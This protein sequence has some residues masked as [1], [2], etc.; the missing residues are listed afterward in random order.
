M[1]WTPL[2]DR[3]STLPLVLTGPVLRRVEPDA[4]TVWLVLREPHEVR[5][6]VLATEA[7]QGIVPQAVVLEGA[8][9]TTAL[10]PYLHLVAVTARPR[11]EQVLAPDQVYAYDLTFGD[12]DLITALMP[13][14][15]TNPLPPAP[16]SY[17]DHQLPTFS[18]PP[19]DLDDLCIVHGS[20]RKPHGEG[21]DALV[22]LD[23][24]IGHHATSGRSRPHQLF[25]TGDQI[26]GDDV[27]DPLLWML[28]DAGETLLGWQEVLPLLPS[29]RHPEE[30]LLASQI[31]PGE[32]CAI[33]ER[34]AGFTAM[35]HGNEE[36]A[37]SHLLSLAE[38]LAMYLFVW[39]PVLWPEE[40]PPFLDIRQA[41]SQRAQGWAKESRLLQDFGRDLGRVRRAL[42]NVPTYMICDDHDVTDDW[43]LNREW[44]DR[45][46]SKPLGRRV[47]TNAMLGYALCQ[48]WGNTPDQF[49]AGQPGDRLLDLVRQWSASCGT[50]P[51]LLQDISQILGL[52]PTVTADSVTERDRDFHAQTYIADEAVEILRR[53]PIA[54]HAVLNW[55]YT[56]R[57]PRHEVLVLDT[58]TWRGYPTDGDGFSPPRLLS[59]TAFGQQLQ[60]PLAQAPPAIALTL[61]V[62]PTNLISLELIDQIQIFALDQGRGFSTDAGDSWNLNAAAFSRL[63]AELF[64]QRDRVVILTGDIHYSSA[65][66]L[67]YWSYETRQSPRACVLAQLTAS[68]YKNAETK[69]RLVHTKL[70]ALV[71]EVPQQWA[72]WHRPPHLVEV[73]VSPE[74]V[75]YLKAD[76]PAEGP[77]LRQIHRFRGNETLAWAIAIQDPDSLPDWQYQFEWIPRPPA[78]DVPWMRWPLTQKPSRLRRWLTWPWRNR[79]FQEGREV[80]GLNN[81]SIVTVRWSAEGEKAVCQDVYWQTP[82]Q[83]DHLV[84]SRYVVPLTPAPP[85]P[86]LKLYDEPVTD[87]VPALP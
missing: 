77:V 39:S 56:V 35:A 14:Q 21:R 4:V 42:A 44:C 3:L 22:M 81:I 61:V 38:Y 17:F 49:E 40:L 34:Q 7:G 54:D 62:L 5:L 66:L 85:P 43:Y 12:R 74:G 84:Y 11:G 46:L 6:S 10:G 30:T 52:P 72:G 70:K 13:P 20:C 28:T 27:A 37:K 2:R 53:P 15:E 55:H 71:P 58:R 19:G 45:V 63:L 57:G 23:D 29:D 47:L 73:Q 32:R 33:A 25:L 8:Q 76:L 51:E 16:I 80:V 87:E 68:A 31:L 9:T 79:W 59:P 75:R 82:W 48:A 83:L 1:A 41:S 69:T 78:Q 65:V 50:R 36:K 86:L 24:F 18:L 64:R 67:H 60:D 26:Y